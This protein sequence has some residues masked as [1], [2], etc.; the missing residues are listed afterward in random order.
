[1]DERIQEIRDRMWNAVEE[2]DVCDIMEGAAAVVVSIA[3]GALGACGG[4]RAME[5]ILG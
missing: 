5:I 3:R 4:T 1:M 2:E